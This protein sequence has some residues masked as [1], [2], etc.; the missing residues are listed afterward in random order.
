MTGELAERP[1]TRREIAA[2][3]GLLV[4]R[5]LARGYLVFVLALAA[6]ALVPMATGLTSSVV[7]SGSM[8][9]HIKVGDV[10]L[11]RPLPAD[12]ETPL[13]RVIT[14]EAPP[15]S[16]EPGLRLHR[17]V[18][19]N[20][21][22]TLVTAGDAN[23]DVD[24]APLDRADIIAVACILVPW[25]GLPAFWLENGQLVPLIG[26][27][28]LSLL[29]LTIE[30][31]ASR[32]ERAARHSKPPRA[33]LPAVLHV[34]TSGK[35]LSLA[36]WLLCAALVAVAPMSTPV[37]A[38]FTAHT[39]SAANSWTA[40][41]VIVPTKVT[42]ATS[43]SNSTGGTPFA[44]QP[45]VEILGAN[46][47]PTSSTAPVTLAISSPGGATLTCGSNPVIAVSGV[48]Q[49]AGCAV[50]KA[51]TYTLT[52][53]SAGLSS[54]IS[55]NFTISVGAPKRLVFTR[56]PGNTARNT[57]FASQPI[58]AVQDAGGNTVTTS[59]AAVTLSLAGQGGGQLT[60]CAANPRS[61]VSGIA[62]F[63]GCRISQ[64]GTY[65]LTASSGS[66]QSAT[67]AAIS[68]FTS[69]SRL[70]FVVSPSSSASGL[71]FGNQ[72]VVAVQDSG[73]NTTSGT[74]SITLSITTPAGATL[75]CTSN[76]KSAVNGVATFSGCAIG[77]AGTYTLRAT[78]S[79]LTSA[80]STTFTIS[81]GPSARLAFSSSPSNS[82]SS[83]AF[84]T[85]PVVAVLDTFGNTVASSA[86]VTL[87]ITTP[88]GASL[89]CT[90]N[91]KA[92]VAGIA[93]FSGCRIDRAGTYTLT[94]SADGLTSG[95]SASFTISAGSAAK[96]VFTTSPGVSTA[97]VEFPTQP[98]VAIQDAAGNLVSTTVVVTLTITPPTGGAV[99]SCFLNPWLTTGGVLSFAGC[100]IDHPGTYTLTVSSTSLVAG[101]SSSFVMN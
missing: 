7:Q 50:D 100:E 45:V 48:A 90:T 83:T 13:G 25:I 63:S 53:T 96:V 99:L 38:A 17:V 12:A 98:A 29:A 47:E 6:C 3:W 92:A 39:L 82:V 55:S 65:T 69:A 94:A 22:G 93:T 18:A 16:A 30:F 42:F 26:W 34:A 78:A 72:P 20:P 24:S 37:S 52:A 35:A 91:P 4:V 32:S 60:N 11:A 44:S 46:G 70:A 79:G 58:V 19:V 8:M 2:S 54:A 77:K 5:V 68:I 101:V 23:Q 40:A 73:G 95:A 88:N 66:L 14:F 74:N 75:T 21:N 9:P 36:A 59:T 89:T 71:P 57:T 1:Q 67:S 56:T 76:P 62:T 10:V 64:T 49:F 51:G 28:V 41:V 80:T 27:L 85:Q 61:A 81:P 87:A 43:P 84:A 31:F 33:G 86:L 15:G 97:G